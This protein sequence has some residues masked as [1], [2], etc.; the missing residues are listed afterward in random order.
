MT[1]RKEQHLKKSHVWIQAT[2]ELS[3]LWK[4]DGCKVV[5]QFLPLSPFGKTVL[6]GT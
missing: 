3:G 4:F 6:G 1:L 5:F 2:K